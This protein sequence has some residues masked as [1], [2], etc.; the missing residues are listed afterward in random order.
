MTGYENG[1]DERY[2]KR[3]SKDKVIGNGERKMLEVIDKKGWTL[4]NGNL[5]GDQEREFTF[6]RSRESTVIDYII[7][8]EKAREKINYFKIEERIELD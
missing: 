7:L 8:N 6:M 3:A 4:P 5:E 1:E 2:R